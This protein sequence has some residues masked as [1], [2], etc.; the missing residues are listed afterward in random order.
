MDY[1]TNNNQCDI[2]ANKYPCLHCGSRGK[3]DAV[4]STNTLFNA[5]YGKS[6]IKKVLLK[7]DGQVIITDISKADV[8]DLGWSTFVTLN[9]IP[10]HDR[11]LFGIPDMPTKDIFPKNV[12]KIERTKTISSDQGVS[13]VFV[14]WF[15]DTES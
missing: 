14:G 11:T 9:S 5:L 7:Y 10:D 1:K 3:D 8:K 6:V 2:C 12:Y 15:D 4:M 13:Q